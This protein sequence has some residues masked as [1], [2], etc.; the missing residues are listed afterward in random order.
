[1][2]SVVA[3]VPAWRDRSVAVRPLGTGPTTR[4][5]LV[6][7]DDE[8]P[9]AW[10]VRFPA[11]PA[12]LPGTDRAGE[13]E[14]ATRAAA[15]G[16]GPP[17]FGELPE[18][19]TVITR[20]LP[21][22]HLE[23][24]QVAERLDDVAAVLK[25]FHGSG[26]L[27]AS[28]HVHRVVEWHARTAAAH[29][30]VPPSAYERLHQQSRRIEQAFGVAPTPLVPC[31]NDL[32]PAK[33]LV[34]DPAADA[35]DTEPATDVSTDVSTD[36][37]AAAS[38]ASRIWLLDFSS[39]G[40]NDVVFDLA[41]LSVNAGLP[42]AAEHDLLRHYFG[43][44]TPSRWARLQLMKVMSEFRDGMRAVSR[45]AIAAEA[46]AVDD[47]ADAAVSAEEHLA[48]CERLVARPQFTSWLEDAAHP[49]A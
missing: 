17:V 5:F 19:G 48:R 9:D 46:G 3:R 12:G 28:F 25:R 10:V 40:M 39:A 18:A 26:P 7:V 45:Q 32:L 30:L 37:D 14:A 13:L 31:H 43:S 49:I 6:T 8:R 11:E 29:D 22:H 27:R 2:V 23:P 44:V 20:F 24:G 1:M 34:S 38:H 15:L 47:A 41:N 21:G 16:I 33:V 4:H 42:E 36:V 35:P